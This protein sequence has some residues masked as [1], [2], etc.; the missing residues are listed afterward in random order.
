MDV[1]YPYADGLSRLQLLYRLPTPPAPRRLLVVCADDDGALIGGGWGRGAVTVVALGAL[2]SVL[3]QGAQRF[4]AVALPAVLGRRLALAA[5][6]GSGANNRKVLGLARELLVPGG[7]VVGHMDHLCALRHLLR[8][9]GLRGLIGTIVR[10]QGIGF[11]SQCLSRLRQA[12][13]A[14]AECFYVQPSIDA[15][16]GLIPSQGAASR[17]HFLR[18]IRSTQGRCGRAGYALRLSLAHAG[19]GGMLQPQLFFWARRPC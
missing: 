19:L 14:E 8:W 4:D 6:D 3:A 16:M 13:L 10:P 12:G 9:S 11:A 17:A 1:Q 7:V 5:V 2:E 18:A 15:P